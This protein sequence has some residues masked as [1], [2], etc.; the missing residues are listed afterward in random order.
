MS[1]RTPK[2]DAYSSS[3]SKGQKS[4]DTQTNK[5]TN[6]YT[7]K[8]FAVLCIDMAIIPLNKQKNTTGQTDRQTDKHFANLYIDYGAL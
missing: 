8:N 7:N 1:Y 3:L 6:L 2:S 4:A 5:Q